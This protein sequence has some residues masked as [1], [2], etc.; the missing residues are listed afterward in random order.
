MNLLPL[1]R[2]ELDG[3]WMFFKK[4]YNKTYA[5]ANDEIRR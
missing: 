4:A 5:D 3:D 1:V 2:K